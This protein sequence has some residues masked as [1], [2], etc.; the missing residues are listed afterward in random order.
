[1]SAFH[2]LGGNIGNLVA[3]IEDLKI[4]SIHQVMRDTI[5]WTTTLFELA[6]DEEKH[7]TNLAMVYDCDAG[8]VETR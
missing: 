4:R 5:G 1:M 2:Q 7:V 6:A 3:M 8:E